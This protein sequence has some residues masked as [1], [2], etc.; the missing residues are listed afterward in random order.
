MNDKLR[1]AVEAAEL[2]LRIA[3][4]PRWLATDKD[5]G[6]YEFETVQMAKQFAP[7]AQAFLAQM[8]VIIKHDENRT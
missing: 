1:E 3:A 6:C 4:D 8:T 5:P 7:L 2:C